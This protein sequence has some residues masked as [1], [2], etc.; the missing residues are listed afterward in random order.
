MLNYNRKEKNINLLEFQ[1]LSSQT[2]NRTLAILKE[3]K[4]IAYPQLNELYR[5]YQNRLRLA[6]FTFQAMRQMKTIVGGREMT[7]DDYD[8]IERFFMENNYP[9]QGAIFTYVRNA[10]LNGNLELVRRENLK[11]SLLERFGLLEKE[12]EKVHK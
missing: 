8:I 11:K 5:E 2:I 6:P 3:R 12:K 4:S 10:Y 9:K 1:S 7:N